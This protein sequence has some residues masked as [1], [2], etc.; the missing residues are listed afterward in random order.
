[1]ISEVSSVG[2]AVPLYFEPTIG[3]VPGGFRWHPRVSSLV[4]KATQPLYPS[5][6][7]LKER[8]YHIAL[9]ALHMSQTQSSYRNSPPIVMG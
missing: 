2:E 9:S 5:L 1:M 4:E 3:A 7:S 8:H 6:L